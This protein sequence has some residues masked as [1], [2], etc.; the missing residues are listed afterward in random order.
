MNPDTQFD[1]KWEGTQKFNP[2]TQFKEKWVGKY[3][4]NFPIA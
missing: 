1:E 2:D 3:S 4:Q